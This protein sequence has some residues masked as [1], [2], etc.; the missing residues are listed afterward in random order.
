[1]NSNWSYSPETPNSGRNQEFLS[2]VTLKFD[3]WPWKTI[4]HL[5]YATLIYVYDFIAMC[6]FNQEL[7]SGNG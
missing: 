4:G 2:H 5:S 3:G 1:M 7:R 6:E